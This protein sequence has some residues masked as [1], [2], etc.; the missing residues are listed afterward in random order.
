MKDAVEKL[1]TLFRLPIIKHRNSE[2]KRIALSRR[3]SGLA[4]I[5]GGEEP[6]RLHDGVTFEVNDGEPQIH[7]ITETG[8]I[9]GARLLVEFGRAIEYETENLLGRGVRHNRVYVKIDG[10]TQ[11][12]TRKQTALNALSAISYA[13]REAANSYTNPY[14]AYFNGISLALFLGFSMRGVLADMLVHAVDDSMMLRLCNAVAADLAGTLHDEERLAEYAK[15]FATLL[16]GD[17]NHVVN[18]YHINNMAA[19]LAD[20]LRLRQTLN[21]M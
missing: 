6:P 4:L 2:M 7:V 18:L 1:Q 20:A 3:Y 11:E 13:Y 19:Y 12:F 21:P 14:T 8:V 5:A 9:N 15:E 17:E 10:V 16:P